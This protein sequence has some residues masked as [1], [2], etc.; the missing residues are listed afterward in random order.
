MKKNVFYYKPIFYILLSTLLI[1]SN[2]ALATQPIVASGSGS[3]K[4][5]LAPPG[6]PVVDINT[7]NG[8]GLS[9]NKF[10]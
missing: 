9:H 1:M 4:V 5:Y 10:I 2:I 6:V 8:A 7:A 3:T